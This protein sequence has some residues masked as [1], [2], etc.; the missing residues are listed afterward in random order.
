MKAAEAEEEAPATGLAGYTRVLMETGTQG[1]W[2]WRGTWKRGPVGPEVPD[3]TRRDCGDIWMYI[4]EVRP[5]KN[6]GSVSVQVASQACAQAVTG[7]G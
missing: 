2:S 5:G 6:R 7:E 3:T 4:R 1:R